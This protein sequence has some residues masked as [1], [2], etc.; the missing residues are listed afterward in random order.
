MS[1]FNPEEKLLSPKLSWKTFISTFRKKLT[2]KHPKNPKPYSSLLTTQ[3]LSSS[4]RYYHHPYR[5]G[6][7]TTQSA[8]QYGTKSEGRFGADIFPD[9]QACNICGQV[10]EI[11]LTRRYPKRVDIES[12]DESKMSNHSGYY[13]LQDDDDDDDEYDDEYESGVLV[14]VSNK[15]SSMTMQLHGVDASAE[16]FIRKMKLTWSLERQRSEESRAIERWV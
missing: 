7:T 13:S 15:A 6:H 16:E 11:I 12:D 5:L 3:Y 9:H 14:N 4:A 2:K 1:C 10:P 8:D